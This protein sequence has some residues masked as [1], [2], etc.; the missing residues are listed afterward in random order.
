MATVNEVTGSTEGKLKETWHWI[1]ET[2]VLVETAVCVSSSCL[3]QLV[4]QLESSVEGCAEAESKR[5]NV[6]KG[7]A[8]FDLGPI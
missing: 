2:R 4:L 7:K 3:C 6:V 5:E 8:H 1:G